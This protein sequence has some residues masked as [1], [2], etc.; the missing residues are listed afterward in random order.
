MTLFHTFVFG[1][2]MVTVLY[3]HASCPCTVSDISVI[4]FADFDKAMVEVHDDFMSKVAS[5][6]FDRLAATILVKRDIAGVPHWL[7]GSVNPTLAAYPASCVKLAYMLSAIEW[8]RNHNKPVNCLDKHVRPMI[9]VS[10]NLATGFIVDILTNTTNIGDLTSA[11][12][13]RWEEWITKRR[14]TENILKRLNL[15]DNQRVLSKT[16]PTNSGQIYAG[17]E[18]VV[19][20]VFGKNAMNPCCAANLMLYVLESNGLSE[21][22]HEYAKSLLYHTLDSPYTA[23]GRGFP[24]GTL[25]YDKT[26]DAYDTTE[27]ISHFTLPNGQTGILAV[28]SNGLQRGDQ[29]FRV[30][31]RF[32]EMVIEKLKLN[33]GG[34]PV[35]SV[36]A[37]SGQ[38]V[39]QGPTSKKRA[40]SKSSP[41]TIG[42]SFYTFSA[43][44]S[45]NP[46]V[47]T[48]T[49][50]IPSEGLYDVHVYTPTYENLTTSTQ[51]EIKDKYRANL[52]VYDPQQAVSTYA[53]I[54]EY[55]LTGGTQTIIIANHDVKKIA[56]ESVV[57]AVRFSKYPS[58]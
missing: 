7:R 45:V 30:I 49:V 53:Y 11:S 24:A 58:P 40:S 23:T 48:V 35:I 31:A 46:D 22:E 2:V 4:D 37:D 9:T 12:D 52:V 26:G 13:P 15:Y 18:K 10:S 36:T 8:C 21:A 32:A 51:F 27:D 20:E 44:A 42:S 17:A 16:Y 43:S 6:K 38:I 50:E 39:C 28:F 47:C 14:Y 19:T 5:P 3:V 25:L 33:A 54:G 34:P 57:N 29:D 55:V 41:D 56:G 1:V